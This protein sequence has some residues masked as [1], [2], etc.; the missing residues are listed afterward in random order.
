MLEPESIGARTILQ[1]YH[2]AHSDRLVL[3]RAGLTSTTCSKLSARHWKR[4]TCPLFLMRGRLPGSGARRRMWLLTRGN[5]QR[6][7]TPLFQT[8]VRY[9]RFLLYLFHLHICLH[10]QSCSV[11]AIAQ[12]LL[13]SPEQY[14]TCLK[15]V[16]LLPIIIIV[17]L[18]GIFCKQVNFAVSSDF[19]RFL[20]GDSGEL[21][22]V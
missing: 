7:A 4:V 18:D 17:K 22:W 6:T 20:F 1:R 10:Y 14:I 19:P 13:R 8:L 15:D 11:S 12:M 9:T 16:P 21:V 2:I 5:T 3:S